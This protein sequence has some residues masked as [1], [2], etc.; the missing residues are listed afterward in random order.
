MLV[1]NVSRII[2]PS[3][4]TYG[5]YFVG[6]PAGVDQ[7][8]TSGTS[9]ESLKSRKRPRKESSADKLFDLNLPADAH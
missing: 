6:R 9:D 8:S 7:A 4:D 5:A 2:G 3:C 1:V